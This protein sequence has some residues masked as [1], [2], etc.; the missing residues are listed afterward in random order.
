MTSMSCSCKNAIFIFDI[1]MEFPNSFLLQT[2]LKLVLYRSSIRS[3]SNF[4]TLE[5][6]LYSLLFTLLLLF[7]LEVKV[8]FLLL[9]FFQMATPIIR[10]ILFSSSYLRCTFYLFSSFVINT[11]KTNINILYTPRFFFFQTC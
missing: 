3:K 7:T 2:H 8:I 4:F 5:V 10:V 9:K 1:G 6:T 11:S